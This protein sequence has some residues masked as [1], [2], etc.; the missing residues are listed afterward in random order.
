MAT[1]IDHHCYCVIAIV[2]P[3]IIIIILTVII[4]I[5]D[6]Y[7]YDH[8][9]HCHHHRCHHRWCCQVYDSR[10]FKLVKRITESVWQEIALGH[11]KDHG[12]LNMSLL[13]HGH[14]TAAHFYLWVSPTE[15]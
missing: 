10:H 15:T 11:C 12:Y 4:I 5:I 1:N 13:P 7:W 3:L 9:N 6:Q 8:R 14:T 2:F